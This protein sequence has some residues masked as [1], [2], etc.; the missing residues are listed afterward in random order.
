VLN[1]K[2]ILYFLIFLRLA[3]GAH[4]FAQQTPAT[5]LSDPL[6]KILQA[7]IHDTLRCQLIN[8]LVEM[9]D[10]DEI[11]PAYNE[12]VIKIGERAL[13][14][15]DDK[16]AGEGKI[17][18]RAYA[19]YLSGAMNNKGYINRRKGNGQ[20]ALE[21]YFKSLEFGKQINDKASMA[22][23]LNNIGQVYQDFGD[24]EKALSYTHQCLEMME[25]LKDKKGLAGT[26]SN[27][28]LIYLV[29]EDFAKALE[30]FNKGLALDLE[31]K[32]REGIAIS[33]N[34]IANVYLRQNK[35]GNTLEYF[36]RSL[37]YREDTMSGGYAYTLNNIGTVYLELNNNEKALEYFK[38]SLFIKE[39]INDKAG[40]AF[41]LSGIASVMLREGKE[42]QALEYASEA[43]KTGKELGYPLCI[44][45][46]SEI[47]YTIYK[48]Q[49]NSREAIDMLTL[50]IRMRDSVNNV[51][52]RKA[53]TKQ[54]YKYEFE[55]RELALKARQE[56]KD[57][58][59]ATESK[60]QKMIITAA[61]SGIAFIV[62]FI[63][64]MVNRF[65]YT[66]RQKII[67][68]AQKE[69][70]D[71]AYYKLHE[72]NKEITASIIYARRIQSSMLT[73]ERYIGK[74]LDRL[75]NRFS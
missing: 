41:S 44:Q 59:H 9:E 61:A 57:I 74:H 70:V 39:K 40:R 43:L 64:F 66:K 3:G 1:Y 67:I 30:Y 56:K 20:L 29:Q 32:D 34:N 4:L 71:E 11:W 5:V 55:K 69:K 36:E 26:F 35:H 52:T 65:R 60:E 31:L 14:N 12:E 63:I 53:M 10:D 33:L 48:K 51:T 7:K 15:I 27:L 37:A 72:K 21:Y 25:V 47:L 54:Q 58:M 2:S 16:H 49:K 19:F 17:L 73:S 8:K 28:G 38:R 68:E 24:I 46:A 42:K 50:S 6:K 18:F 45:N 75:R 62:A 22:S 23:V 13:Q